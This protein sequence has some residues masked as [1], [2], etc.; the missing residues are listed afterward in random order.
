MTL[1]SEHV[2]DIVAEHT[3]SISGRG[4]KLDVAQDIQVY[5]EEM[6]A[7]RPLKKIV[8]CGN[9]LGVDAARVLGEALYNAKDLE[10]NIYAL[11]TD[12]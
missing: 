2:D 9:T 1:V 11:C 3:F 8:L 4:L 12:D 5:L 6:A 10:V 7:V